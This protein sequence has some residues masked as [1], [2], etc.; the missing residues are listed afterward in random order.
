MGR[1]AVYLASSASA[2]VTGQA[3][4]ADGGLTL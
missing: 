1:L 3:L 4:Y 2:H